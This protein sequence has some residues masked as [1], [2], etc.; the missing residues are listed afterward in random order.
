MHQSHFK[1]CTS[2]RHYKITFNVLQKPSERQKYFI[3]SCKNVGNKPEKHV[4][5]SRHQMLHYTLPF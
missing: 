2:F 5:Q 3:K 1:L 4:I